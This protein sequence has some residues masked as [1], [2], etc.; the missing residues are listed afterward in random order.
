[1][2]AAESSAS[3]PIALRLCRSILRRWPKA[4]CVTRSSERS[5]AGSGSA[6]GTICTIDE[7]TLGGGVKA[8]RGTSNRIFACVRQ[9]ASTP[10]R[11]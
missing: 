7:V 11:P 10:S 1:M 8:C 9:P 6:R 2:F 3:P 4:A 5:A